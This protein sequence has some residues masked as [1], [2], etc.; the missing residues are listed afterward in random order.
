MRTPKIVQLYKLIDW[1]STKGKIPTFLKKLPLDYSPLSSNAW[2][3][4]FID[5]DGCFT[6]R[7]S[8]N[9]NC[10]TKKISVMLALVQ[11]TVSLNNHSLLD[12]MSKIASFLD[13]NLKT[14]QQNTN[15]QYSARTVNLKGNLNVQPYLKKYPLFSSK[16]LDFMVW[17]KVLMM[18]VNK[19]HK[20]NAEVIMKL[21]KS[22][23]S[24]RTYFNWNHLKE[25]YPY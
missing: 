16:F 15:P 5:S 1:I 25:F 8:D 18:M 3:S 12:I 4:G 11:K 9:K 24:R 23:N 20:K 6:V 14:T 21:K 7:V 10:N 19:E 13:C 2:L 22:M 17:E